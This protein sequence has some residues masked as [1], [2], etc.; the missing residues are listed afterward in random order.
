M[1]YQ[2]VIPYKNPKC[3][4]YVHVVRC[5]WPALRQFRSAVCKELSFEYP[6]NGR[7]LDETTKEFRDVIAIGYSEPT[8]ES[9]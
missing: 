2:T 1:D 4:N 3:P 6:A 5:G 9:K 7:Y 8:T